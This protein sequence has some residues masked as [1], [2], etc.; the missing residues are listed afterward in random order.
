MDSRNLKRIQEIERRIQEIARDFGLSTTE[1]LFEIVPAQRVLEGIAYRFPVNFS[2]WSFGRDYEYHRTIY[3]HTGR[4][5]PYEQV[6]NFD[7]PKAFLVRSNPFAL[8]V[9]TIAHV[10]GHVDFFLRNN[11]LRHGRSIADISNE[12]RNAASRFRK[13]TAEHQLERLEMYIDAAMSI[14]WHQHPDPFADD[15]VPEEDQ[16]ER[17]I[18]VELAKLEQ[19]RNRAGF[20]MSRNQKIKETEQRIFELQHKTPVQPEYDLLRF[21]IEHSPNYVY[22]WQR[23]VLSVVRSQARYLAPQRRTKL[24]NEGWAVYWHLRIMRQLFQEGLLTD[25]EH[26]VF[27]HFHSLV[28][29]PDRRQLNVYRIGLALFEDIKERWDRGQFGKDWE[30]CRDAFERAHWDKKLGKGMEKIF[31]V[32]QHYSDRMAIEQ[33]FTDEFIHAQDLYIYE[34]RVN[35]VTGEIEE[36][37][38][39]DRPWIIRNLLKGS[40]TLYGIP[41]VR[42]ED[43]NYKN[44]RYLYLKHEFSGFELEPEYRRKTM[45]K[46][47]FLWGGSVYLE[48]AII[49]GEKEKAWP[50]KV[51]FCYDGQK[52]SETRYNTMIQ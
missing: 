2:H 32:R 44:V 48:S 52:H 38:V 21:I 39:E 29:R 36:V 45:E 33:F 22:P 12:A 30:E 50:R 7:V 18:A 51:V 31:E 3:E 49:E 13:Y 20:D 24:L 17:L 43:G 25:E 1:I 26:G 16:R 35:P 46:I 14:Q 42:V 9:L 23:D 11:F 6:W 10:F 34:E 19:L 41:V 15:D 47:H 4:G 40:F 5:I 37:I 27:N 28:V 8:N